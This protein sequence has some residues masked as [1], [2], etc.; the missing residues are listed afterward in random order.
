MPSQGQN[1]RSL[2]GG[3]SAHVSRD[4]PGLPNG[5]QD[6]EKARLLKSREAMDRNTHQ[7]L[8]G[9]ATAIQEGRGQR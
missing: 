6:D 2:M 5:I 3:D 1:R 7:R 9:M 4:C 8:D